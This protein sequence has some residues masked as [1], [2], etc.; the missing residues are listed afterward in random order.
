MSFPIPDELMRNKFLSQFLDGA[1]NATS[2]GW[3]K[4]PA[5]AQAYLLAAL[6][7][8]DPRRARVVLFSDARH[9]EELASDCQAWG[10]DV[11]VYPEVEVV[12]VQLLP[13]PDLLAEKLGILHQLM[14]NPSS[15]LLITEKAWSQA[16]PLPEVMKSNRL[17]FKLGDTVPMGSILQQLEQAGYVLEAL[18]SQRG[19]MARRGGILDVFSW[20]L[21][22]PVRI[23]WFGDEVES[24]REFDPGEQISVRNLESIEILLSGMAALGQGQETLITEYFQEGYQLILANSA[25]DDE[26]PVAEK[27][28]EESDFSLHEFL[29]SLHRDPVLQENRKRL[30][31]NNLED[32]VDGEWKVWLSC[33]NEGEEQRFREWFISESGLT[34]V[35]AQEIIDA[36]QFYRSALLKGFTWAQA[37]L[38]VLTDAEIFGRYQTLRNLRRLD[39]I[40]TMRL[41]QQ[42]VDFSEF[43]DGDYV[44]HLE[45]GI[46][47]YCGMQEIPDDEGGQ[48]MRQVL[49]LEFSGQAKL[50]V[51]LEQAYLISKYI[52]VGK[53]NP[54]LDTLGGSRWD[55][56]KKQAEQAVAD[57]ATKLLNIHAERETLE[58]FSCPPDTAWQKEFEEAFLYEETEDQLK[59]ITDAKMDMESARPMDRLIC[60]DVGFGKTEVAIRAIFKAVM[61][62]KQVAFLA[63]TTVLAQQH[64]NT[65]KERFADYPIQVGMMSRFVRPKDQKETMRRLALGEVDVA[66]GTHRVI[67]ADVQFKDLGLVV[68]DEEQR[69]GVKQ[70]EKFKE[71]FRLVDVLTLSATPIP[72]TL[73]LSLMG[74]RDMSV[75]DTPPKSRLPVETVV[76]S[77]DERMV[78]AAIEREIKRGGQV[79]YLHNRIQTIE[80]VVGRLQF[81]V[82]EAKIDYGH[83]QMEENQLE[84]V[85][86][87]FVQ[88]TTDILVSTTIIESGIDIPNANTI[89]IDRA[90]RFGLADLYQLRGR[91]GRGGNRAYAMLLLP[92]DLMGGDA[93]KRVRAIKQYSDL[94][95]G[96]KI[97]MRDLEIRGAGNLLGTAQSGQIIAVGFELYC[98]LL[99]KAV[100]VMKGDSNPQL[101]ETRMRL[102]FLS[103]GESGVAVG[104]SAAFIPVD[105]MS[106]IEWRITAYREL[107][108]LQSR[109]EWDKLR[110]RWKDRFGPWPDSVELLLIYNRARIEASLVKLSSIETKADK[111]ILTRNGDYVMIGG[112]FPR[113]TKSKTKDKL[114]EIEKWIL[115]LKS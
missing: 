100:G 113:L 23:E 106:E 55:K 89:I 11:L 53:R 68:I 30:L 35:R 99:K 72:R 96:F 5:T 36:V 45:Y 19:Q 14:E 61:S 105:Y 1:Q 9:Q 80:Q 3:E 70:K 27:I 92:R 97:A 77:Y 67:S 32:W 65:L 112:R 49:V 43:A 4:L 42:G 25:K 59:A 47:L 29:H 37:R 15:L 62:G 24:I 57:Y 74:A 38:V 84:E 41:K 8:K 48:G 52:G 114:I 16:V 69:F 111:L 93:G 21:A 51:P 108:E 12:D 58:G 91:V 7:T 73:Y 18:A 60:G 46:A 78:R 34:Q 40:G 85:M 81:L 104:V 90:D 82:P 83:G 75:I 95:A 20:H 54:T 103:I 44:V 50:F 88:G 102:D 86:L 22:Y 17:R 63:P 6:K 109:S 94:G 71:R 26:E 33:N 107:A 87:R 28:G 98:R 64:F 66:V 76:T 56:A 39:R 10:L 115:S 110:K 31:V 79:F 2:L 13:D 101:V